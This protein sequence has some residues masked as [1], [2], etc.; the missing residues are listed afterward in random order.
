MANYKGDEG[1][2][3][4]ATST[5]RCIEVLSWSWTGANVGVIE[6]SVKGDANRSYKGGRADGGSV[7]VRC[8]LDYDDSVQ[9][10][11][12]DSII[13]GTGASVPIE[14]IVAT[15]K[16]FNIDVI[17][18]GFDMESSEGESIAQG[19]LSGKVT[20]LPVSSWA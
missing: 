19:T 18:T 13:A 1:F 3:S 4:Y 8:Q 11:W 14:V 9:A 2:V 16:Q 6:D 12:I 10:A 5:D 20:G 17:P 7:Q 15:G